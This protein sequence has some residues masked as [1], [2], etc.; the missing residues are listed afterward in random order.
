MKI[1]W[2]DS[3]ELKWWCGGTANRPCSVCYFVV[4]HKFGTRSKCIEWHVWLGH[5]NTTPTSPP[6]NIFFTRC[7]RKRIDS[8]YKYMSAT[9]AQ[10][11][12]SDAKSSEYDSSARRP[13]AL[14]M[15]SCSTFA[16]EWH[17]NMTR[18]SCV[19]ARRRRK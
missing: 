16:S 12:Q 17:P 3:L 5:H 10:L 8:F 19:I 15:V 6:L 13:H 1:G 9:S 4:F 2:S 14:R 7:A 11:L 18:N